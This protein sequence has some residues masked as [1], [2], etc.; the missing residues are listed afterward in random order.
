MDHLIAP[1]G[2]TLVN[3]IDPER[4]EALK[5]EAFSLP[6]LDIAW[7]QQCELEM[8]M[9]GAYSPLTGYMTR[10]QCEQVRS[11]HKLDDGTFWPVP[12]TLTS[13]AKQAA[14]FKPG[15][16]IA[17]RDGEGF[18]LAV[19]TLSDSWQEADV[20]H[21]GGAIEGAALPPH[22]DF[23]AWR[24]TPAELRA[25]FAKRGWRRVA[26]WQARQPMHRAQF[27]FCLKCA[28]ENEANLL[29]HPL[30]GGDI[31]EAPAYFGLVRS[32][33]AIHERFPAATTQLS[34]L[35]APPRK[36]GP[37]EW[38]LRTIVARNY[39]CSLLIAGGEHEPVGARRRGQDMLD[40]ESAT[41]L[42]E[43]AGQLGVRLVA[44]PRMVYV[45]DRAEYMQEA[46][47]PEGARISTL[48]GEEFHRRMRAGLKIPAWYSFP[49]LID[50]LARQEPPRDQQG[51]TVFFT[52]LSGAG[53]STIARALAARLMEMGGRSVTLLDGDIVRRNLS[54]ELGFN[55]AH[56][57]INVRRI[58][59]VASEITKNRG[60]AVCA[61][62]APYRQTRRDVRAMIEAVGGFVEIHVAT[63]IE[64]CESRDR[65][66]LYAKAR[67]GLIPEFTGVSDPYEIPENPELSIDTTGLG[68]DEAVQRVLLKL[69]YEGYLR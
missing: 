3:L 19:L 58:G 26:A 50:E 10:A 53:K 52:G 44:Y 47:V 32:F 49:E 56:R 5:Q 35:P 41:S 31:T 63:P 12:I 27:E 57:D 11:T 29:L 39:G 8:L 68:I 16:R 6:S 20:W 24:H 48:T 67:A 38:L 54:S 60:I 9:N 13:K 64:T 15:D 37:A 61:P 4:V 59:F 18:M 28:V 45:E 34:I 46:E 33:L 42:A 51:F 21:L 2:G 22:P 69:E 40:A 7:E 66:G 62:I 23:V 43:Q 65:K 25:V 30:A 36:N 17:L 55:K 14:D 1:Y